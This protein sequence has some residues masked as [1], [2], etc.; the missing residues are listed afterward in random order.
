M[1]KKFVI[2]IGLCILG[3][4]MFMV[5]T[6]ELFDIDNDVRII[7]LGL[8]FIGGSMVLMTIPALPEVLDA[9]ADD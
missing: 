5:G 9:I 7:L 6:S 3:L 4:G 8:C 2:I 1:S